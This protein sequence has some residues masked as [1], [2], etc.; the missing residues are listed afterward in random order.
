MKSA[1]HDMLA[2][3]VYGVTLLQATILE[4]IREIVE[5]MVKVNQV[6]IKCS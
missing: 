3:V 2:V 5:V 1:F 4:S 6:G